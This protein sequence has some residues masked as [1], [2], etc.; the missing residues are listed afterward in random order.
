MALGACSD[1]LDETADKSGNAYIY[2]MDQLYGLTGDPSL[3]IGSPTADDAYFS[4]GSFM[5]E[6][7]YMGDGSFRERFDRAP[8]AALQDADL[9]PEMP[10]EF[11]QAVAAGTAAVTVTFRAEGTGAASATANVAV[12]ASANTE[13]INS[14]HRERLIKRHYPIE[15][16]KDCTFASQEECDREFGGNWYYYFK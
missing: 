10:L 13:Q 3:Y 4:A 1:F 9:H 16:I 5:Q 7:F 15:G 14:Y 12:L 2:H 11:L 6:Q 8:A